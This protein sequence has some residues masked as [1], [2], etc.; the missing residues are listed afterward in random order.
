[1]YRPILV[2]LSDELLDLLVDSLFV[3]ISHLCLR[4]GNELSIH[5]IILSVRRL[6][7]LYGEVCMARRSL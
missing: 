3:R 2:S 4:T 6:H 1:M 7:K 5:T